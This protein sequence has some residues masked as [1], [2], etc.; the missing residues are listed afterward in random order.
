MEDR[1]ENYYLSRV[2]PN[3]YD[4]DEIEACA[5]VSDAGGIEIMAIE[6]STGSFIWFTDPETYSVIGMYARDIN[7][8]G[9]VKKHMDLMRAKRGAA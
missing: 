2:E 8:T 3:P 7:S 4:G 1:T 9:D 6:T 5:V